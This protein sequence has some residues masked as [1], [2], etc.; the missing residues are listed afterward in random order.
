MKRLIQTLAL[1]AT[2]AVVVV[3]VWRD[4]GAVLTLKRAAIAYLAVYF[5]SGMIY[6]AGG[7]ACRAAREKPLVSEPE[8]HRPGHK[9]MQSRKNAQRKHGSDVSPALAAVGHHQEPVAD[10]VYV[11]ED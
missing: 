5:V 6:L 2:L 4:Y 7:A 9:R 3:A 1:G 8:D 11:H 10:K